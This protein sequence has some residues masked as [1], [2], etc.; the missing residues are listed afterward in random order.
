MSNLHKRQVY[1]GL[2]EIVKDDKYYY[3]SGIGSKFNKLTPDGIKEI[4]EYIEHMAPLMIEKDRIE[5]E[6]LAK[7]FVW[8]ELKK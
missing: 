7:T 8:E 1:S 3:N 6:A 5:Q 4:I 2:F